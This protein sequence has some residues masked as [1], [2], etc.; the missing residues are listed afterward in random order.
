MW[1][2]TLCSALEG[3]SELSSDSEGIVAAMAA[4][5]TSSCAGAEQVGG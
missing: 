4:K 2:C 1:E 5:A 3:A